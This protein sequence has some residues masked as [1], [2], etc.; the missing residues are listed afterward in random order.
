AVAHDDPVEPELDALVDDRG[1]RRAELERHGL[2]EDSVTAAAAEREQQ[3]GEG[4]HATTFRNTR[5]AHLPGP[6][7]PE[8]EERI[9]PRS[10]RANG[11]ARP[12]AGR[13][14]GAATG[15]RPR[16]GEPSPVPTRPVRR[17]LTILSNERSMNICKA[18]PKTGDGPTGW[19][20]APRPPTRPAGASSRRLPACT[21][22]AASRALR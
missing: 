4:S 21:R 9:I 6:G 12:A 14:P 2:F 13:R 5:H 18:Q 7:A 10:A 3:E 1:Q 17:C 11:R 22:S 19:A 8:C 16:P 20:A 15:W